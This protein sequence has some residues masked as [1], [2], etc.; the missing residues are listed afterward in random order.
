MYC[1]VSVVGRVKPLPGPFPSRGK[2]AYF[3]KVSNQR[4]MARQVF[5][6]PR[7]FSNLPIPIGRNSGIVW[8]EGASSRSDAKSRVTA[9]GPL[10]IYTGF[11]IKLVHLSKITNIWNT[12]ICQVYFRLSTAIMKTYIFSVKSLTKRFE[13][14]ISNF[15]I[16]R[17][18]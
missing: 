1:P 14:S 2:N 4:Q 10:P 11:P 18:A 13:S 12:T 3:S 6:L 9:A 8:L 7:P 5:W 16:W 17:I 15:K